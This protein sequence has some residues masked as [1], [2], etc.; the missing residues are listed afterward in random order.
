MYIGSS[1]LNEVLAYLRGYSRGFNNGCGRWNGIGGWDYLDNFECWL[2][3]TYAVNHRDWNIARILM[4]F[5]GHK[6]EGAIRVIP[7]LFEKYMMEEPEEGYDDD[8]MRNELQ[9]IIVRTYGVANGV[10]PGQEG[11]PVCKECHS[12]EP[13]R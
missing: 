8:A 4:H 10:M 1:S 11:A 12:N 6:E 7:G 9:R 13:T 2:R 5:N 3:I